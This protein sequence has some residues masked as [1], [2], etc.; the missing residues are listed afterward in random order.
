MSKHKA[1]PE[2]RFLTRRELLHAC[3]MSFGALAFAQLFEQTAM[4]RTKASPIRWPPG[5]RILRRR[6]NASS[7]CL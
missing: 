2:D 5:R 4:P 6:S 1:N 3:G 7:T